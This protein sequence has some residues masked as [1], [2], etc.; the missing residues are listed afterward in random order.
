MVLYRRQA[1]SLSL[2]P[3]MEWGQPEAP[4]GHGQWPPYLTI[5]IVV[6]INIIT[7]LINIVMY[8]ILS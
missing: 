5:V 3:Q 8:L 2:Q 4:H 6:I 7:V 1:V